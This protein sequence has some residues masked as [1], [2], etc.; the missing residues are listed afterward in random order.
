MLVL[1]FTIPLIFPRGN[2]HVMTKPGKCLIDRGSQ[3]ESSERRQE[4]SAKTGLKTLLM[5]YLTSYY[6]APSCH[7]LVLKLECVSESPLGLVKAQSAE[8]QF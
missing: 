3:Q 6:P 1:F 8:H 7:S 5:G 2:L 4:L